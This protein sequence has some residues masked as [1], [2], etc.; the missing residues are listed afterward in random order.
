MSGF[1][2]VFLQDLSMVSMVSLT[3]VLEDAVSMVSLTAV[4]EDVV[5]AADIRKARLI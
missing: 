3:A 1:V 4:L 5:I 2:G